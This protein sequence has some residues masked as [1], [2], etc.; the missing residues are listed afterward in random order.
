MTGWV[1]L[2][3]NPKDMPNAETPHKVIT[4]R[5]YLQRPQLFEGGRPKL[6]NLAR[7]YNYQSEGYY[8][9]LLA[10]ARG[11]RTMPA[12]ETMLELG[13]K[14]LYAHAI[15]EL[16][17]A[18]NKSVAKLTERPSEPY[19]LLVCFNVAPDPAYE[20]F[21]RHLFDWFRCPILEVS[22]EP[23]PWF[24]IKRI[25]AR[26]VDKLEDNEII[27]F[28]HALHE[29]TKREWRSP[30]IKTPPDWSLAVLYDPN[31]T[32]PPSD[33][34]SLK[35]FA[36]V[37][38]R[39]KV[40][41]EPITK[42]DLNR[43]AEFDAL[44]I[45]ETTSIDNHTYQFA[46]RAVQEGMPVIDDPV[47]MIR[48]TNK[49]YL[50]ELLRANNV[51][52]PKTVM[53]AQHKDLELAA[54]MLG[55]PMVVKI[56]DGSFSR[57]VHKAES[58]DSLKELADKLFEDTDLILAQ[59]FMPTKLDWRVGVLGGEPLFVCQY[60]MAKKH[61]Q[62]IQHK[63]DGSAVEGSTKTFAVEDAPTH[64]V[65]TGL[66]AAKLIGNGLYGVDIKEQDGKAYVIE[67]NDNPNLDHGVE[68]AALK[69]ALWERLVQW[70]VQ[71]LEA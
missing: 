26:T 29:H 1:I 64:V 59:E 8:C 13:G 6:I 51:A 10:E 41:V 63:P 11:H 7:S 32:L 25:R 67:V 30:K 33:F 58:M 9:A 61:W 44:F 12:A 2:V 46:R 24:S 38:E 36:R 56:P 15:P 34:E 60:F 69:D 35:R 65:E 57:G 40:E 28:R 66:K 43:L 49:I 18:L 31:E 22:I 70:F 39:L 71:R 45:R 37:A 50:N 23:G 20:R 48:C 16:E 14:L 5:D 53:I 62:I 4:T 52:T 17:D 55:F 27:F 3:E 21:A 47:S 19:E 54:D 42:R 68:D